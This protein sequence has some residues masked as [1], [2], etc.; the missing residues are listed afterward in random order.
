MQPA[1]IFCLIEAIVQNTNTCT[2]ALKFCYSIPL[3]LTV[4]E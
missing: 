2:L 1:M 4:A 3:A